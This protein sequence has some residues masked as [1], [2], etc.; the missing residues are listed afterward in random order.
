M[1]VCGQIRAER[2]VG[3]TRCAV[4]DGQFSLIEAARYFA[5]AD[6]PDIYRDIERPEADA[7]AAR[8]LQ[9]DLAY[10]LPIIGAAR[11]SELW[12][13]FMA[14]FD[15]QDPKLATNT[16]AESGA[17][18][19]TPATEATFDMGVLVI[20]ASKAGCLWVEDED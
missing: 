6:D 13:T 14:L 19:W 4:V 7:I 18:S 1:D 12:T 8:V 15:G 9:T 17:I 10:G 2:R 16:V 3:I 5:L 11:A 20:G